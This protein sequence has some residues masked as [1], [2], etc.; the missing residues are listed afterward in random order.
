MRKTIKLKEARAPIVNQHVQASNQPSNA[1]SFAGPAKA[2]APVHWAPS[3]TKFKETK[4]WPP[5]QQPLAVSLWAPI[6]RCA[7]KLSADEAPVD[8]PWSQ[9]ANLS[10][11]R[12]G[13]TNTVTADFLLQYQSKARRYGDAAFAADGSYGVGIFLHR[14]N[15]PTAR[16]NDRGLQLSYSG[17][18]VPNLSNAGPVVRMG[19][20]LKAKT[21]KALV[22][23]DQPDGSMAL[24]D[25]T[26]NRIVLAL[27]GYLLPAM[28][29]EPTPGV[30]PPIRV[31][32]DGGPSLYLDESR[33]NGVPGNG[34]ITG[35]QLKLGFNYAPLGHDPGCSTHSK[36]RFQACVNALCKRGGSRHQAPGVGQRKSRF[37]VGCIVHDDTIR[38]IDTMPRPHKTFTRESVGRSAHLHLAA[39]WKVG[40]GKPEVCNE[41]VDRPWPRG[42]CR[43]LLAPPLK[44]GGLQPRKSVAQRQ[45]WFCLGG[46]DVD[47]DECIVEPA[48]TAEPAGLNPLGP[49]VNEEGALGGTAILRHGPPLRA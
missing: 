40:C 37:A 12:E 45:V 33:G 23:V 14:D 17:L 5:L 26:K 30:I 4:P 20:S 44:D 15:T 24:V 34:R 10:V 18:L 43:A 41:E 47:T 31:F 21:G 38:G 22:E 3:S 27:G 1:R 48:S 6:A 2:G 28:S 29:G 36:N 25:K 46:V 35:T 49:D 39:P 13:G 11:V 9:P 16:R 42:P 7:F 8:P 32:F 19:Y